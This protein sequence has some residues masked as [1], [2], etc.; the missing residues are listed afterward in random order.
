[1]RADKTPRVSVII[2]AFNR[3][4]I[5]EEAIASVLE[6]DYQNREVI[7]VDDG[8]TDNTPDILKNYKN[9]ITVI[10]QKNSGV[11]AARNAGV[12]NASGRYIAFLDSDDFWL[13]G[14]LSCQV[15]FFNAHPQ[16]LICQTEEV[17][18]RNGIRVNP[19][20]RHKKPSGM[21]FEQSLELCLVSPSAV[22]I[23]RSL[24]DTVGLFDRSLPA[25]EDYDLWL[26]VSCR[27]PVYLV[28]RALTVKRGGHADQL[29]R[30]SGLDRYRIQVL[31]KIIESDQLS[32]KQ[33]NAAVKTL[34]KKCRIF[35]KGC[36]HRGRK[37]EG[38]FYTDLAG[39][40]SIKA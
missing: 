12:L 18:I 15:E 34:Q 32:E 9:R 27:F 17:W 26:R 29:S 38:G 2:P 25:C 20:K 8:S 3:G 10:Q 39:R 23:A 4:W 28:E 11:S 13:P 16:A 14:K 36:L 5:I 21:I 35:A 33:Y 37:E 24:L 19:K 6:Q 31:E 22:M 7:I 40:Y 30:L 1:M